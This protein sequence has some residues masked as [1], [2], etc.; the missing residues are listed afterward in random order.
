MSEEQ[1]TGSARELN[2]LTLGLF[3]GMF[4]GLLVGNF[5][6][7]LLFGVAIGGSIDAWDAQHRA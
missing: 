3:L 6:L 2:H 1:S 7:G 4:A 5:A